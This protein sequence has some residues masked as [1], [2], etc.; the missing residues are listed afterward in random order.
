MI[1]QTWNINSHRVSESLFTTIGS[2][3]IVVLQ[4]H[5]LDLLTNRS[6]SSMHDPKSLFGDH[7]LQY[8]PNGS[9]VIRS[10]LFGKFDLVA[11]LVEVTAVV[12][13]IRVELSVSN[14][15]SSAS[16]SASYWGDHGFDLSMTWAW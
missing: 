4:V 7:T 3:T 9:S 13:K 11:D 5:L 16:S 14:L 12:A 10:D 15:V 1:Q 2:N 6:L 8:E